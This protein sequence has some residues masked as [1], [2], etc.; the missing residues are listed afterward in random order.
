MLLTCSHQYLSQEVDLFLNYQHLIFLNAL[1]QLAVRFFQRQC[2]HQFWLLLRS[3]YFFWSNFQVVEYEDLRLEYPMFSLCLH[4]HCH[5]L[6]LPVFLLHWM[7][8]MQKCFLILPP[9]FYLMKF[10]KTCLNQIHHPTVSTQTHSI[11]LFY[12]Q[13][14]CCFSFSFLHHYLIQFHLQ[15]NLLMMELMHKISNLAMKSISSQ[16]F[17]ILARDR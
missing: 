3:P 6:K 8:F 5:H 12:Y 1:D 16:Y 10:D 4:L 17:G 11:P 2:L 7:N 14:S 9:I 13:L 15:I